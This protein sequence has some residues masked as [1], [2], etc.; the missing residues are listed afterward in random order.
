[1]PTTTARPGSTASSSNARAMS[2]SAE[3]PGDHDV[4]AIGDPGQL[5]RERAALAQGQH[6][7][8]LALAAQPVD[9]RDRSRQR[10]HV[11][12]AEIGGHRRQREQGRVERVMIDPRAQGVEHGGDRPGTTGVGRAVRTAHLLAMM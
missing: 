12:I 8:P 10:P 6:A 7:D 2:C 11:A 4:E 3:Q 1:M 9:P 5:E